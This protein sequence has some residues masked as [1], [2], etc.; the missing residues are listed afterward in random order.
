MAHGKDEPARESA[1]TG[2]DG[3][4]VRDLRLEDLA[5]LVRIDARTAGRSRRA[6][7]ERK[8]EEA[9]RESGIKISLAAEIEGILVGFLLGRLYYGEFGL[10]EPVAIID[11]IGVDPDY[12]KRKVGAALMSQLETNMKGMGIEILQTQVG[13]DQFGLLAFMQAQGFDPTCV[14]VLQ[15]KIG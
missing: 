11:S 5:P 2:L 1:I 15:K 9:V 3:I 13:W 10:P 14:L 6:Y 7:Y 8:L 4:L 12:Q